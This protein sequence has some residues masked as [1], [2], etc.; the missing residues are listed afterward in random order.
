MKSR[1]FPR[2]GALVGLTVSLTAWL[3]VS[4]AAQRP[5]FPATPQPGVD[6]LELLPVQGRVSLLGGAGAN[7]TIQAGDDGVVVVD[8]G[9]EG[10]ADRVLASIRTLSA[11]PVRLI[12]STTIGVDHIGG[13]DAIARTGEP[14]YLAQNSG[15]VTIPGAQL[16]GHEQAALA[17]SRLEGPAAVPQR[18]WPFDT[19]FGPLKTVYANGE[20]IEIHHVPG[21]RTG[22]DVMVFFRG[23]DVV[24][25]GDVY[26]TTA[27]PHFEATAGGSLQGMLDA[28]NRII[29]F[30]VPAFNQMG[31]TR[32]IPGHGRISNESDVVEYRD[33]ATIVR[34]RIRLLVSQG[35]TLDEVRRAGVTRDYDGIYGAASGPWT[36]DMFIGAVYQEELKRRTTR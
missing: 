22:G 9:L 20:A 29:T 27:Y 15:S 35:R 12:V 14:L 30:A 10:F 25:A 3:T 13:N 16:V 19:F 11:K 5:T 7:I 1:A 33:M 36:T 21:A 17:L 2:T 6:A 8:T 31:G 32:V 18:L 23:S 4:A 24:S 28:L 34:D 26:D